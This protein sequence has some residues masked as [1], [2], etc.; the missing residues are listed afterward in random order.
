[1]HRKAALIGFVA[2]QVIAVVLWLTAALPHLQDPAQPVIEP[3]QQIWSGGGHAVLETDFR[4]GSNRVEVSRFHPFGP[5]GIAT[6][7]FVLAGAL[8]AGALILFRRAKV[9]AAVGAAG[10]GLLAGLGGNWFVATQWQGD[11]AFPGG[12]VN[13]YLLNALSK[14]FNTQFFIGFAALGLSTVA[15]IAGLATRERPYGF[16]V[17]ALNWIVI[18]AVWVVTYLALYVLPFP[19]GSDVW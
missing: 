3:A 18:A 16:H 2:L 1:M 17:V 19:F 15:V 7:F 11:T 5:L 8:A 10:A 14:A 6:L 13:T 12:Y 4:T 9:W